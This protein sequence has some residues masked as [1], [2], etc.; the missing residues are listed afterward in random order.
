MQS[1][2]KNKAK[3]EIILEKFFAETADFAVFRF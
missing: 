3:A 2:K 1:A